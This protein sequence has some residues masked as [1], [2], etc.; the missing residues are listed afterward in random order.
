MSVSKLNGV[1]WSNVSKV[2]GVA[3]ADVEKIMGVETAVTPPATLTTDNLW[4]DFRPYVG[5]SGTTVTDQSGN[6]RDATMNNGASV[7]TTPTGET[8]FYLDGI[9]DSVLY[10]ITSAS[11]KP[12]TGF[13][14]TGESWLYRDDSDTEVG[15]ISVF[16][17]PQNSRYRQFYHQLLN[18]NTTIWSDGARIMPRFYTNK[19]SDSDNAFRSEGLANIT[20]P[21]SASSL[22]SCTIG[23]P[24]SGYDYE[25][26][27][28]TSDHTWYHIVTSFYEDSNSKLCMD[29]WVNGVSVMSGFNTTT[30]SPNYIVGAAWPWEGAVTTTDPMDWGHGIL[31]RYVSGIIIRDGYYGDYRMYTKKLSNTEVLNNFNATK[32]NYGY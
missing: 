26:S 11:D 32:S 7:S 27:T 30:N 20:K 13:P 8:A 10:Q 9:N 3:N 31:D 16:G 23:A 29:L 18:P 28:D 24:G 25:L 22:D 4:V 17:K 21:V 2:N 1:T 12:S 15:A 5:V 19:P 14:F 6:G